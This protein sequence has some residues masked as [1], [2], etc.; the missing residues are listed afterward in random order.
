MLITGTT[1]PLIVFECALTCKNQ[2]RASLLRE[3]YEQLC[4]E[5]NTRIG[6]ALPWPA[7]HAKER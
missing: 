1:C 3:L 6:Q 4:H 2:R 5:W 7:G